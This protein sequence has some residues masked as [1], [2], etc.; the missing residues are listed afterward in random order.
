MTENDHM[1]R[2]QR[3][4]LASLISSKSITEA[5]LNIGMSEKT[6]RRY[7]EDVNFRQAL[8]QAEGDLINVAGRRLLGGQDAALE[9]L[10]G[11]IEGA[12]KE[13]DKRLAAVSWLEL[14]LRWR[15]SVTIE[16]RIAALERAQNERL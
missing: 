8:T 14:A 2:N 6:I 10:A 12:I 3:R 13:S 1:T 16:Q 9:A 11:L 5:A 7:L 15:E 4:A